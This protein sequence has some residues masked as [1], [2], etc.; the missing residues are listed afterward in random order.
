LKRHQLKCAATK[1]KLDN[2]DDDFSNVSSLNDEIIPVRETSIA[3]IQ[4]PIQIERPISICQTTCETGT[5]S[6][7][8]IPK[9]Q[10]QITKTVPQKT[11]TVAQFDSSSNDDSSCN[12]SNDSSNALPRRIKKKLPIR[13][14]KL[15]LRRI[16]KQEIF[17]RQRPNAQS[18]T[19]KQSNMQR[20]MSRIYNSVSPMQPMGLC[21]SYSS[22][23]LFGRL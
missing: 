20:P 8:I 22:I 7:K 15:N 3:A 13:V 10:L 21:N 9:P 18:F 14:K 11:K 1:T 2:S 19:P 16:I 23:P 6:D 17:K 12:E 4:S 5:Q